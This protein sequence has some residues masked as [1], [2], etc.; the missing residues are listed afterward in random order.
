MIVMSFDLSSRC[1]GVIC[2]KVESGKVVKISSCPIIP[3]DFD[4]STLGFLKSKKKV[5]KSGINAYL[6]PGETSVSTAE[7][8]KRD[9][10]VRNQKDLFIIAQISKTIANLVDSIHPD[11][12]L[13]EKN[14]IFN[15]ILTSVLLGKVMG[16][17]L[18]IAGRA[19]VPVKEY[20]VSAVR[21]KHNVVKLCKELSASLTEEELMEIPDLAKR[22]LR[23][24]LEKEYGVELATDDESDAL[25]V[26]DHY[27]K[28]DYK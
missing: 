6:Y 10:L 27:L 22:A 8:K 4:P 5:G 23:F 28:E 12:I 3:Q 19:G 7:K 11:L 21:K 13:V 16:V 9:T 25:V 20:T 15:G 26:L 17:L 2:A 14:A 24:K 18:G 1:I